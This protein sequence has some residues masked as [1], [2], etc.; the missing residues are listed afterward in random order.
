MQNSTVLYRQSPSK[1]IQGCTGVQGI[2]QL[3]RR[4][5]QGCIPMGAA[6]EQNSTGLCRHTRGRVA[7]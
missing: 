4:I 2:M 1:A 7:A 5:I 6:A 3:L